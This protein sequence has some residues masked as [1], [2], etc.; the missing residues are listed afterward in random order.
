MPEIVPSAGSDDQPGDHYVYYMLPWFS[1]KARAVLKRAHEHAAAYPDTRPV[2]F[3]PD[4]SVNPK[5][6][7][8][9]RSAPSWAV[10]GVG[11]H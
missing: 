5:M 1:D 2:V 3:S 10:Q 6:L 8:A 7:T 9:P 11:D 4:D